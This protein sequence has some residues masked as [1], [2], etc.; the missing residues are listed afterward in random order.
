[1]TAYFRLFLKLGS[2]GVTASTPSLPRPKMV[3]I[4]LLYCTAGEKSIA[5]EIPTENSDA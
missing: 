1:M 5:L 3:T 2:K 4:V